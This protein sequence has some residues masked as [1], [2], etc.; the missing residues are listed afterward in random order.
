MPLSRLPVE[1]VSHITSHLP[2]HGVIFASLVCKAWRLVLLPTLYR[3]VRLASDSHAVRFA[4]TIASG[5]VVDSS[6]DFSWSVRSLIIRPTISAY[7][8]FTEIGLAAL[9][10]CMTHLTEL[11]RLHCDNLRVLLTANN[12]E[13]IR[14]AQTRCPKLNSVG[15]DIER[16][17]FE[18]R[19]AEQS[20]LATFSLLGFKNLVDYSL[21]LRD[22]YTK[23]EILAPL[24]ILAA[25]CPMLESLML[26]LSFSESDEEDSYTPEHLAGVLGK[27]T[28]MPS[29]RTLHICGDVKLNPESFTIL[30]PFHKFLS[31]H[32]HIKDLKIGWSITD[33]WW[34][35]SDL[36]PQALACALPS[37]KRLSAPNFVCAH[38]LRS[39]IAARLEYM[40][41][42][43]G[44]SDFE[45]GFESLP[46]PML[47]TLYIEADHYFD[48]LDTIQ[49]VMPVASGLEVLDL[50]A[51]P[52]H[53]HNKFLR[54]L[55]CV[56]NLQTVVMTDLIHHTVQDLIAAVK[57]KYPK[58][59]FVENWHDA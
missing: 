18:T 33:S 38:F 53:C 56:P 7:N 19:I 55:A 35:A 37:L 17:N 48:T 57:S 45:R 23:S 54:L 30:Q 8:E 11:R 4:N 3:M 10:L 20:Q 15:F 40:E 14:L 1:I 46:M 34:R 41:V 58:I 16:F 25:N 29:L 32:P 49:W 12:L 51:L 22:A 9:E 47:R 24:E 21:I 27:D 52:E 50:V 28:V 39:T 13:I 44:I 6:L 36:D 31:C 5:G 59:R 43:S 2:H 26:D 42:Q